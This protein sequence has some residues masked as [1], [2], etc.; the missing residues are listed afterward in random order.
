MFVTEEVPWE[1]TEP[2]HLNSRGI[3]YGTPIPFK[4]ST[5]NGGLNR[6]T[7]HEPR[8]CQFDENLL[9]SEYS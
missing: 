2:I 6:V 9:V 5:Q 1:G 4:T 8:V 3:I 7:D